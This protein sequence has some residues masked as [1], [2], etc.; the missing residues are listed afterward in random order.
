MLP[1]LNQRSGLLDSSPIRQEL[2][3]QSQQS[4]AN[5]ASP[6]S[7][8]TARDQ[9]AGSNGVET[10]TFTVI[11]LRRSNSEVLL[12]RDGSRFV[13]PVV[14][15]PRW[16]R[17]AQEISERILQLWDLKALYLFQ[18]EADATSEEG[19]Q[20]CVILEAQNSPRTLP[21]GFSW[22]SRDAFRNSLDSDEKMHSLDDA[23]RTADAYKSGELSGPFSKA[24]W[25]DELKAWAQSELSV[26][27]LTLT[28]EFRQ[29][30]GGPSFSLIRL[31]STGPAVWF[32]AVGEPNLHEFP[33]TVTLSKHFPSY[34]PALIASRPSWNG[35]LT[36]EVEGS[37]LDENSDIS[38]WERTAET[39][40]NLQIESATAT[41]ALLDARCRDAR[42]DAL[43]A[44]IDAFFDVIADLMEK[45]TKVPPPMLSLQELRTLAAQVKEA[46]SSLADLGFPD[47]LGH[48]DF[49]PGNVIATPNSCIFLDWAE[50]YVGH[51]FFTFEYLRE[52]LSRIHTGNVAW[53]TKVTS[54]YAKS[55]T[56]FASTD[57]ISQAL[58]LSPL[59]AV[60]A[61]AVAGSAWR[62]SQRLQNPKLAGYLRSLTRRMQ[63]EA[64]LLEDRRERCLD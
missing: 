14:M 29:L 4:E 37:M 23:L 10:L 40:A 58:K 15:I 51:P 60:Y 34:L 17:V 42:L 62:D 54:C 55:W 48:F 26:K 6:R 27:G 53:E 44:Q 57:E 59:L 22:V 12:V 32:K 25:L 30:N 16:R 7:V 21:M 39:L 38:A 36:F 46:C 18:R 43:L 52:H 45:Q 33:I 64:R 49:N 50:A 3:H 19:G 8:K 28:G 2:A 20:Q 41:R 11:I 5:G 61:Y 1:P 56:A 9:A 47:T 35:W 31:E 24:G 63:R 13:L